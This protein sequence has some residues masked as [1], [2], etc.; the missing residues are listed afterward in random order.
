VLSSLKIKRSYRSK[1]DN[2]IKDFYGPCLK[3]SVSFDRGVG[4]FTLI[5]LTQIFDGLIPFFGSDGVIRLVTS[6]ELSEDDQRL[7]EKGHKKKESIIESILLEEVNK[8]LDRNQII[9]MEDVTN[10]IACNRLIIKIAVVDHGMYHEKIGIFKDNFNNAIYFM[11]SANETIRGQGF[12]RESISVFCSWNDF[13][14]NEVNEQIKYFN[15]LWDNKDNVVDVYDFPEA[16]KKQIIKN[17][18]RTRKKDK[19]DENQPDSNKVEDGRFPVRDY[20]EE[21]ISNFIANKKYLFEMATG[22][23]KT[24]TA[25]IACKRLI[26]KER[27]LVLVLVPMIDLQ[28]QW[29]NEFKKEGVE[30]TLFGGAGQGNINN[31]SIRFRNFPDESIVCI[32]TYDTFFQKFVG[33]FERFQ[34][35]LLLIV[36]EVHN[37]TPTQVDSLPKNPKYSLGLSATPKRYKK[38]ETNKILKYFLNAGISPFVFSIDRAIE[39]GYLSQYEYKMFFIHLTESEFEEYR[40]LSRSLAKLMSEEDKDEEKI[41]RISNRRAL[42]IKKASNKLDELQRLTQSNDF[43]FKNSV[44]YCGQGKDPESDEDIIDKATK[45]LASKY[46]VSQFTSKTKERELVLSTFKDDDYDVLVAIKCFDEGIDVPKLGKIFVLSSDSSVRQTIQR[47]GR[48]LRVCK[49]TGKDKAFIY[50]MITLPPLEVGLLD[51]NASKSIVERELTRAYEYSRL[52]ESKDENIKIIE[53]KLS[54]YGL[55]LIEVKEN[56]EN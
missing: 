27:L 56:G 3:E 32:S 43:D 35:Q 47:R 21:A 42:V 41:E 4:Y 18:H 5:S 24:Y 36:D 30:T 45:I 17:Y 53:E 6:I 1:K 10:L 48:V 22:T 14:K 29:A 55:R 11:G 9:S 8:Q 13:D 44:V 39:E 26:K 54:S 12:N 46:L 38:S 2:L 16:V 52:S 25:I 7:I 33:R 37:L 28:E 31:V 20:Q 19:D 49:E 50:D 23:G 51:F 40:S 15:S 34:H